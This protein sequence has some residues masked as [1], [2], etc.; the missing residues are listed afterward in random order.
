MPVNRRTFLS[1]SALLGGSLLLRDNFHEDENKAPFKIPANFSLKLLASKWGIS[2]SWDEFCARVKDTGYDGIEVVLPGQKKAQE[3]LFNATEKY[4]LEYGFQASG[5][6]E[7]DFEKHLEQFQK[8][9]EAAVIFKPLFVNC[10]S[11][12]DFFTFEQNQQL[13]DFTTGLSKSSGV[14]IYHETHR[15]RILFAA[16]IAKSFIE[17][18][19]ELRLTLDISHWCNVHGTLLQDQQEA[20]NHALARTDH[21]HARVGHAHGP[22]ITDPRAPEWEREVDAHFQWWDQVVQNK[23]AQGRPLTVKTEFGPPNYMTTVPYTRQP[24]VD[25]WDINTYMMR[26]WRERYSQ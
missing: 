5:G 18:M 10:H 22:Q 4:K 17:K 6:L 11:G 23:V 26:L 25:L 9:V 24:L 12:R 19:P 14:N 3:E 8:A 16:Q 15:A 7:S 20:V 1:Q 21:I 2:G 13:I